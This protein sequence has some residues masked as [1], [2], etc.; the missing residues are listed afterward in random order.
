MKITFEQPTLEHA[1]H[2]LLVT[3]NGVKQPPVFVGMNFC[4]NHTLLDHPQI[5]LPE[6]LGPQLLRRAR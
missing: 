4:G 2:V 1:V 3:P 5:H 6:A